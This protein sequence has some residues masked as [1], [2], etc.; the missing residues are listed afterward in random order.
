MNQDLSGVTN[1]NEIPKL[2]SQDA[3]VD[4]L[5]GKDYGLAK[6]IASTALRAVLIS[7]GAYIAGIR[8]KDLA[9]ASVGGALAIETFV[10]ASTYIGYKKQEKK[11]SENMKLGVQDGKVL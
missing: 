9:K 6:V 7:T 5:N 2:P 11:E 1:T 10:L 4:L 3:V 8:G